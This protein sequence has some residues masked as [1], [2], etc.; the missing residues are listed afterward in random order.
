M[1][2]RL[3]PL[4]L[5][6]YTLPALHAQTQDLPSFTIT[7][8]Q[9]S[10]ADVVLDAEHHT[11]LRLYLIP[12]QRQAFADF[13]KRYLD[14]Q[15]RIIVN[16]QPLVEPVVRDPILGGAMNFPCASPE[17]ALALAKALM[18]KEKS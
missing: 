10:E 2:R 12:E 13:T 18:A 3:I 15:V 6:L 1:K 17:E 11:E 5:L 14:H 7:P 9:V 8:G 4:A 16:G